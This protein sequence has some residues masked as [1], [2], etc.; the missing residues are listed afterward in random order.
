MS[1]KRSLSLIAIVTVAC[2]ACTSD[3]DEV[4]TDPSPS[5]TAAPEPTWSMN[6]EDPMPLTFVWTPIDGVTLDSPPARVV[7]AYTES[8]HYA[9]SHVGI[10]YGYPGFLEFFGHTLADMNPREDTL[11]ARSEGTARAA[12]LAVTRLDSPPGVVRYAVDVC[13]N[14][15]R[16]SSL[17]RATGTWRTGSGSM[18]L[19]EYIETSD[20]ATNGLDLGTREMTPIDM[21]SRAATPGGNLFEGWTLLTDSSHEFP[22]VPEG[23]RPLQDQCEALFPLEIRELTGPL[24]AEPFDPGW[25]V[26]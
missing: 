17:M 9:G 13:E 19:R 12:I 14:L 15:K 6:P 4:A 3:T 25:P 8:L 23:S 20:D 16:V 24:P 5:I 26:D 22:A 10:P 1:V 2:T 21:G 7:R 18:A 11:A